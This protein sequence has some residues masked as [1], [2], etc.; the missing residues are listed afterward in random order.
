[1]V[2]NFHFY[3]LLGNNCG[4]VRPYTGTSKRL[5]E[6]GFTVENGIPTLRGYAKISDLAAASVP[7]YERYQRP[8]KDD[9]VA[10]IAEF[11]DN[12]KDEAKFLPEVVLSVNNPKA[13]VLKSYDHKSFLS[14]SES[15]KGAMKNIGYYSL[16]VGD[17]GLT[18]VDGNHRLEAGKDKEYCVPFSI[19]LW[20]LDTTD[21]DNMVLEDSGG[22]NTESESFLFYILL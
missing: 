18:R 13:A 9:H 5:R 11:L 4:L 2:S 12:C 19:V 15:A 3:G 7:Q 10:D 1:M 22:D 14:V 21:I 8:L 17:G 20:N 6:M 16:E